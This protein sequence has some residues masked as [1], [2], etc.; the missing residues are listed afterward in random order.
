MREKALDHDADSSKSARPMDRMDKCET[1]GKRHPLKDDPADT[2]PK[3]RA[4]FLKNHVP[5]GLVPA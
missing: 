2:I 3:A 4:R 1:Y 5:T